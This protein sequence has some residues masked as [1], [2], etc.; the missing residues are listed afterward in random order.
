MSSVG[1]GGDPVNGCDFI[2]VL[3]AFE[4]DPE[5]DAV[6]MIGEIGGPQEVDAALWAKT[7]MCIPIISFVVGMSAPPG[8]RMGHAGALIS[9]DADTAEVKMNRMEEFG[10]HVVRNPADIGETV[11]KVLSQLKPEATKRAE[12]V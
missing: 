9:G 2:T 12:A 11:E 8:R 6:V 4:N 3:K 10:M 1:I 5:T 7:N